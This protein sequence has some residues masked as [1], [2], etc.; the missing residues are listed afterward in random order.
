MKSLASVLFNSGIQFSPKTSH[1]VKCCKKPPSR[2]ILYSELVI[3]KDQDKKKSI[4]CMGNLF[5]DFY[6]MK[7]NGDIYVIPFSFATNY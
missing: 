3:N 5:A 6:K 4:K 7:N 2:L 1:L